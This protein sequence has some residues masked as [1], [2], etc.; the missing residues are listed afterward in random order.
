MTDDRLVPWSWARGSEEGEKLPANFEDLRKRINRTFDEIWSGGHFLP[1]AWPRGEWGP[2]VDLSE[3]DKDYQISVELPGMDKDD[4]E[5][6][7]SDDRLTIKG[8][9]KS[10]KEEK[11][12]DYHLVERSYGSFQRSFALPTGVDAGKTKAEFA[13]GVLTIAL[14]K[15]AEAKKKAKKVAITSK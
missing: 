4:V 5:L 1:T 13:K 2:K 10:E 8:E 14:H 11:E 6:L 7:L 12:K 15:T 3:T 9:K